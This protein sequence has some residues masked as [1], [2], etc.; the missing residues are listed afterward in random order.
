MNYENLLRLRTFENINIHEVKN[1]YCETRVCKWSWHAL[2]VNIIKIHHRI[3]W[4]LQEMDG[5]D[6][7]V[8]CIFS[9]DDLPRIFN[10]NLTVTLAWCRSR[11]KIPRFQHEG[12]RRTTRVIE[13]LDDSQCVLDSILWFRHQISAI[14]IKVQITRKVSVLYSAATQTPDNY[15]V[16][17]LFYFIFKCN[18]DS[19]TNFLSLRLWQI[20][21]E[22]ITKAIIVCLL[23]DTE[24]IVVKHIKTKTKI[25]TLFDMSIFTDSRMLVIKLNVLQTIKYCDRLIFLVKFWRV[26]YQ[27]YLGQKYRYSQTF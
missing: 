9:E 13:I 12:K 16:T 27:K 4:I 24:Q 14:P 26:I 23:T 19:P 18:T 3:W 8:I 20:P 25:I 22:F 11:I 7:N 1:F 5:Q 17:H 21:S 2:I 15:T 10:M 6:Q